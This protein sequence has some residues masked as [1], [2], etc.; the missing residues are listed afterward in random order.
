MSLFPVTA[1]AD[2]TTGI[3]DVVTDNMGVVLGVLAFA[4]GVGLVTRWFKRG[5]SKIG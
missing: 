5:T 2:L 4:I 3:L 1:V